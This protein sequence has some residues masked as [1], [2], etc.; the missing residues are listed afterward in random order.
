MN[1]D[2]MDDA[3]DDLQEALAEVNA[4]ISLDMLFR[5]HFRFA[6]NCCPCDKC[7]AAH[8]YL[9]SVERDAIRGMT[10]QL[11]ADRARHVVKGI[12]KT[13]HHHCERSSAIKKFMEEL[14]IGSVLK[15]IKDSFNNDQKGRG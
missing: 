11:Q 5:I 9:I 4:S 7:L 6:E 8:N 14:D 3:A 10:D 13:F 15:E 2:E 12:D 1:S